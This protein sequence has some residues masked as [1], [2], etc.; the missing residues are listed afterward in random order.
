VGKAH[1][2]FFDDAI[3]AERLR[4]GR[5]FKIRREPRQELI[6]VELA[7]RGSTGSRHT[8]R[9]EK[10]VWVFGHR[11]ERRIR[12]FEYEFG[13]GVLLPGS[14]HRPL[15]V[16]QFGHGKL[17]FLLRRGQPHQP[18]RVIALPGCR[19]RSVQR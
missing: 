13:V 3:G 19:Y 5:E 12:V 9:D 16:C 11:R 10:Y 4:Q 15:V 1:H 2:H 7:D 17:R 18:G 6:G 14:E 8:G